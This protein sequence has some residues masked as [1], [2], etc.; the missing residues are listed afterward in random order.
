MNNIKDFKNEKRKRKLDREIMPQIRGTMSDSEIDASMKEML[1]AGM[2]EMLDAGVL[3]IVGKD[4]NG[5][6]LY[7]MTEKGKKEAAEIIDNWNNPH[8]D[9]V[10]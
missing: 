3:E 4:E 8:A 7:S 1:D 9:E 2:K 10:S 5:D 6:T